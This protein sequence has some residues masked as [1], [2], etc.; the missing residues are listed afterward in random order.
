MSSQEVPLQLVKCILA[1]EHIRHAPNT[2]VLDISVGNCSPTCRTMGSIINAPTV[3]LISAIEQY[4][5]NVFETPTTAVTVSIQYN[6]DNSIKNGTNLSVKGQLYSDVSL[7]NSPEYSTA[8]PR[9]IPP[10]ASIITVHKKELKSSFVSTPDPKNITIG[11]IAMT[12]ISPTNPSIELSKHH[13]NIVVNDT[14]ST[15]ICV[16]FHAFPASCSKISGGALPDVE[17][18]S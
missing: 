18:G 5:M 1:P 4:L 3:W 15:Y 10:I 14:E 8:F 9:E 7:A 16:Q 17:T 2:R 6:G 13:S 11:K 12:P